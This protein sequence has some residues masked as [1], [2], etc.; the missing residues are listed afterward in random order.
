MAVGM[1][2]GASA[3]TAAGASATHA[4]SIEERVGVRTARATVPGVTRTEIRVG[5]VASITNVTNGPYNSANDG[6]QAYFDMVNS[7]GG[8]HGRRLN[9]A[10]RRDDRT[11]ANAQEV[12]ALLDHDNV[13]A[14]LPVAT[15]YSFSGARELVDRSVPTFGWGINDEWSGPK[16]LFGINGSR[17]M[18]CPYPTTPMLAELA[19]K[20]KVGV[21]AYA[22]ANSKN[23]AVNRK[24]A[25]EKYPTAKVAYFSTSVPF[26]Q[27]DFSAEV[28]AMKRAG[29]S[30]ISHCMDQNAALSLAREVKKQE[31]AAIQLLPNGYDHAFMRANASFLA[32]SLVPVQFAPFE[33]RPV[34]KGIKLFQTWMNKRGYPKNEISLTGWMSA[35]IFVAGLREAGRQV[36]RESL[37]DAL[38]KAKFKNDTI[39]GIL[40]GVQTINHTRRVRLACVSVVEVAGDGSFKPWKTRPGK[41]FLCWDATAAETPTRTIYR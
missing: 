38:N 33:T 9:F 19:G 31:L 22:V 28:R 13:F 12:Q 10:V 36:T 16:N 17:C 20:D 30:L 41:P 14:V 40:P 11:A 24:R 15:I 27:T 1:L 25:F 34:P 5:G 26:G 8:V 2:F 39:Q 6:V 23:C 18:T 29:V 3:V 4:S 37:I 21:L 7:S 32:G 35:H